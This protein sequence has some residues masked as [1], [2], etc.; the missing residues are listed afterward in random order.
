MSVVE[1]KRTNFCFC[2][3]FCHNTCIVKFSHGILSE[4][5]LSPM[6]SVTDS[7][8]LFLPFSILEGVYVVFVF[9]FL[10]KIIGFS[11]ALL[12]FEV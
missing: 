12:Q 7:T 11:V 5:K 6:F 8:L 1:I 2:L 3:T 9:T 4:P 10:K